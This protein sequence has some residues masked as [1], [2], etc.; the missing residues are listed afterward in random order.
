MDVVRCLQTVARG[1]DSPA[2]AA[3]LRSR[4]IHRAFRISV[5]TTIAGARQAFAGGGEYTLQWNAGG[6]AS[7][8]YFV[9]LLAVLDW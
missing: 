8:V 2:P 4:S 6:L 5:T 7:G 3:A 9:K 1:D